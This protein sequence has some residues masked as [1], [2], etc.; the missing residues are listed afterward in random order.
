MSTLGAA[1]PS[2]RETFIVRLWRERADSPIWLGQV[3]HIRTGQVVYVRGPK[4]LLDYLQ[5]QMD[6]P[7]S[8]PKKKIGLK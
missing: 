8:A 4:E 6:Q 3:Q 7:D 2:S 1:R 5:G